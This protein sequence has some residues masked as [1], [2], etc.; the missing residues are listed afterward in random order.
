MFT[1]AYKKVEING[2]LSFIIFNL[3]VHFWPLTC[4]DPGD[5]GDAQARGEHG[6]E[7]DDDHDPVRKKLWDE[8]GVEDGRD[9]KTAYSYK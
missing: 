5:G 1:N 4:K 3:H 8:V 7:E 9:K 2:I 6:G